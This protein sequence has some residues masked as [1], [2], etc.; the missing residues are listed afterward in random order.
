MV[1]VFAS[2]AEKN[3]KRVFVLSVETIVLFLQT[4]FTR[5]QKKTQT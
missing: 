4:D 2:L 3:E 5:W 1:Q